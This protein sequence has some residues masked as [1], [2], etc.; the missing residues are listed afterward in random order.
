MQNYRNKFSKTFTLT[1]FNKRR[2]LTQLNSHKA[3]LTGLTLVEILIIVAIIAVLTGIVILATSNLLEQSR[4]ARSLSFSSDISVSLAPDMVGSWNFDNNVF[5]GSGRANHGIM[6]NFPANSWVSGVPEVAGNALS[7]NGVNTF[8]DMSDSPILSITGA[9]TLE[10]WVFGRG[11]LHGRTVLSKHFNGEFDLTFWGSTLIYYHGPNWTLSNV[12][13][14]TTFVLDRWYHI[15]VTREVLADGRL[16]VRMYINGGFDREATFTQIP[17]DTTHPVR[18]GL[19]PGGTQPFNGTIDEV[20]IFSA[21]MPIS[22]IQK[23]YVQGVM[24]LAN[25]KR[26]SLLYDASLAS[27]ACVNDGITQS[28]K[29]ERLAKLRN[30][31]ELA[32]DIDSVINSITQAKRSVEKRRDLFDLDKTLDFSEYE[33]YLVHK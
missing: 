27:L 9:L 17:P 1:L 2:G 30:S 29:Q 3:N 20:R 22:Y 16:R 5:D 19:R 12:G 18:I 23:R 26:Q 28:E 10:A 33:Q 4:R 31:E 7:F 8:V 21:A 24:S 25:S 14:I 32:I 11:D 6:H 15:A 13:S